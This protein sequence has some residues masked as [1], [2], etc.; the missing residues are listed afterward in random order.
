MSK[1]SLWLIYSTCRN[2][3]RKSPKKKK[4]ICVNYTTPYK[5][6]D[7]LANE[8]ASG[9]FQSVCVRPSE[10]SKR[11]VGNIQCARGEVV[12]TCVYC[13]SG[14]TY[15]PQPQQKPQMFALPVFCHSV[16][17]PVHG[18]NGRSSILGTGID[19]RFEIFTVVLMR[20]Q[21]LKTLLANIFRSVGGL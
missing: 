17:W 9:K 12:L 3:K 2:A 5:H 6:W 1:F 11:A 20:I 10:C 4:S 7:R 16:Y 18:L 21:F 15:Q 13:V 8:V 19:A 14:I